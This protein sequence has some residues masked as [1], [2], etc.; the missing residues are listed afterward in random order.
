MY[1]LFQEEGA[2]GRVWLDRFL[3]DERYQGRHYGEAA[4]RAILARLSAEYAR[5]EVFLSV[6]D[7]ND[8]AF[9]LYQNHGFA[10]NGEL[11]I[12]GERVMIKKL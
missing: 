5:D 7:G 11:D 10:L 2:C 8:I 3:I 9:T 6:V 12:N 4:L 1:G